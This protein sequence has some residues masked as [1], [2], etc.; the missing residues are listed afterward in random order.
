MNYH[1]KIVVIVLLTTVLML[2]LAQVHGTTSELA[3]QTNVLSFLNNVAQIDTTQ[4]TV[5]PVS[6]IV[7]YPTAFGGLAYAVGAL[8]LTSANSELF[9]SYTTVNDA[10]I[11]CELTVTS[12]S[13]AFTHE[14]ADLLENVKGFL[15]RYQSFAGASYVQAMPSMLSMIDITKNATT[16]SGNIKLNVQN[17]E[18]FASI[19]WMY[20]SNNVDFPSKGVG[21]TFKNGVFYDFGD[22]WNLYKVGSDKVQVSEQE[23]IDSAMALAKDYKL[24]VGTGNGTTEVK[25]SIDTSH[26]D[27]ILTTIPREPLTLYPAWTVQLYF[28]EVYFTNYGFQA[29]IWADTNDVISFVP[30]SM[31]G[32]V[33][34]DTQTSS[35]AIPT[36]ND[37]AFP[38]TT[39]LIGTITAIVITAAIAA[40]ALKRRSK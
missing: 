32:T 38:T 11:S 21:V 30:L 31:G 8:N 36:N 25:F 16:T 18:N 15:E 12:G 22:G 23:A 3:G 37:T 20:T 33:T 34:G 24:I 6:Y 27:T 9:V 2:S 26:V 13:A 29:R 5:H 19:N 10:L 35:S 28:D 14:P 4:Y 1:K 17:E 39:Y 40:V 7:D